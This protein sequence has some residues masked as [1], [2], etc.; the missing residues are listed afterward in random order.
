MHFEASAY[1]KSLCVCL[2][3]QFAVSWTSDGFSLYNHIS[4][5]CLPR[6]Q[7]ICDLVPCLKSPLPL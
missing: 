1:V 2:H 5:A 7:L 4:L 6:T 3:F